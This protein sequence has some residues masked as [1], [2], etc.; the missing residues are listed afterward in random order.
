MSK[1]QAYDF[2]ITYVK[3]TQNIVADALSCRPH[4][5]S[6]IQ[7]SEDWRHLIVAE[8]ARDTLAFDIVGGKVIDTR[9]TP[10]DYFIIYKNKIYLSQ[11][12]K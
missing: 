3:G 6:M 1:L 7:I 10:V 12:Q 8:Y 4:P 11:D 2:D 9:Y 5:T